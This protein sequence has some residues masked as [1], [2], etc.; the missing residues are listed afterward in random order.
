[1]IKSRSGYK[2]IKKLIEMISP[3]KTTTIGVNLKKLDFIEKNQ[4]FNHRLLNLISIC[5]SSKA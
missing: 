1:M 3:E 5:D 2:T 4:S